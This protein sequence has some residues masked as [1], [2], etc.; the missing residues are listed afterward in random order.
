MVREQVEL[1]AME[2]W[3]EMLHCPGDCQ[4]LA[5]CGAVAALHIREDAAGIPDGL[6]AA[7]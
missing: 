4:A 1:M 7:I 3:A 6:V 5:L 2:P